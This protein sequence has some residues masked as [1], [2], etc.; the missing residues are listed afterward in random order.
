[1]F[2]KTKDATLFS[3][4]EEFQ[5]RK[6]IDISECQTFEFESAPKPLLVNIVSGMAFGRR[7]FT[8]TELRARVDGKGLLLSMRYANN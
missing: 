5:F 8:Q 7:R 6:S 2:N 1:M 4:N 3:G